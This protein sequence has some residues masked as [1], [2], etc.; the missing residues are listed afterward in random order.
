M[1]PPFTRNGLLPDRSATVVP[2]IRSIPV[3]GIKAFP[4]ADIEP[5]KP[6][7][8][9]TDSF[10]QGGGVWI[11][12][13]VRAVNVIFPFKPELRSFSQRMTAGLPCPDHHH[14]MTPP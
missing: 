1:F 2:S 10:G 13:T 11:R 6:A 3:I 8:R 12:G 7:C 4:A 14:T 5:I 9:P